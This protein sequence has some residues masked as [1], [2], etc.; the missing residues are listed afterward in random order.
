MT[1]GRFFAIA[2]IATGIVQIWA[3]IEGMRLTFGIGWFSLSFS[4]SSRMSF[5]LSVRWSGRPRLLRC[6]LR[7]AMGVVAGTQC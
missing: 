6:P 3:G 7:L 5:R 1:T 2:F 4:W